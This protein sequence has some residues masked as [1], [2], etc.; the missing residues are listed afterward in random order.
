M[1][2]DMIAVIGAPGLS[3]AWRQRRDVL[4][5]AFALWRMEVSDARRLKALDDENRWLKKLL[6]EAAA[7]SRT[8]PR[9]TGASGAAGE[10]AME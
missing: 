2:D 4:H 8:M 6:A 5:V 1:G 10:P 3:E 7:Q 9:V